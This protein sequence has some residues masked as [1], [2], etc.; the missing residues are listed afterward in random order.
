MKSS[1]FTILILTF[2]LTVTVV[3]SL[4]QPNWELRPQDYEF[5]MAI[6]GKVTTDGYFSVNE[7]DLVAAF[8]DGK[9]R[10]M[11]NLKYEKFMDEYFAYL[12]VYSNEPMEKISF[13]IF[14]SDENLVV[15][16]KDTISFT[17]NQIVGSLDVPYIF[18]SNLLNSEAKL[19]SFAIP[20]QVGETIIEN[21]NVYLGSSS[22]SSLTG[23]S[24]NFSTSTGAKV[25]VNGVKQV[26]DE[27]IND[28]VTPV[29]YMIVSADFSDTVIYTVQVSF[30]E[31]KP[32]SAIN[33]SNKL[34]STSAEI[35][36]I[37]A[38]LTTDDL[39]FGDIHE[40]SLVTGNGTNDSENSLFS[41]NGDNLILVK[42]LNFEDN[43]ILNILIR[44]KDSQ[45]AVY[46]QNFGI[47]VTNSNNPPRFNSS[48]V[49]YVLQNEIFV[50]PILVNDNEGN[51]IKLSIEGLPKWLTY[52]SNSQ[53]ISGVAGND[54][55]GDYS[56]KIKAS[57]GE[58]ES[59][60]MVVFSVINV[61]DPPEINYFIENQFFYCDRE[62]VIQLPVDC[63]TDP[64]EGD[65][66]TFVLSTENNSALPNWLFFDPKT[67][68]VSGSPPKGTEE[69]LDLKLTA[70][71]NGKLKEWIVFK[72]VVSIPTAV[73]DRK[74][75][76]IFRCFPNP[77][78]EHAFIQYSIPAE[79]HVT[80][81]IT[82]LIGAEI[83]RIV[84]VKQA[85]GYYEYVFE[86]KNLISGIYFFTM[87]TDTNVEIQKVLLVEKN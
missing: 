61:N 14:N 18:S 52:N 58:M 72:L 86:A 29:R 62:N 47:K 56:F 32:P 77:F 65:I 38:T 76:Q 63:I 1:S 41:I 51:E 15:S 26:S 17:I 69:S 27:T 75:N 7:N 48:P 53:L 39:D 10:G 6:T 54:D 50:Y 28:F 8:V 82:N 31:N 71:D 78:S 85:A 25:F 13:K 59:V 55:V 67:F 40:F 11:T 87:K 42:T 74:D 68:V 9:C 64:D 84:D 43:Q 34:I 73:N 81:T 46:E 4:A 79:T 49:K 16:T 22:R 19:L 45:G 83:A 60:Q 2:W 33:L 37:V 66:L 5:S 21:N 70:T 24:A 36:S 12:M 44:V 30:N 23:I 57:D 3:T 80:F 35:S 20:D